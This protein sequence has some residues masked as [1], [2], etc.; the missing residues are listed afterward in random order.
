MARAA[1][2]V[3]HGDCCY[4]RLGTET[5]ADGMPF[6]KVK[7][8]PYLKKRGDCPSRRTTRTPLGASLSAASEYS[9]C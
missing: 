8:C 5:G 7:P 2:T 9:S 6:M 1:A 3:P 4:T